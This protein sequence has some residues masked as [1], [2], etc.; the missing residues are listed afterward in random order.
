MCH[1]EA[2]ARGQHRL[3]VELTLAEVTRWAH[4]CRAQRSP[5]LW[6]LLLERMERTG[7]PSP[8]V[9]A[10]GDPVAPEWI[11]PGALRDGP[12]WVPTPTGVEGLMFCSNRAGVAGPEP[13]TSEE[14][15]GGTEDE[16]PEAVGHAVR[17]EGRRQGLLPLLRESPVR[18][19]GEAD[20]NRDDLHPGQ[21]ADPGVQGAAGL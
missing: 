11:V 21:R 8:W 13:I 10:R 3:T 19:E 14:A 7:G 4:R 9:Y 15:D 1:Q 12:H 2:I 16:G 18:S 17:A 5:A 6:S 20:K